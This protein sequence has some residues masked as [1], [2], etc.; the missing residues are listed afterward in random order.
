MPLSTYEGSYFEHPSFGNLALSAAELEARVP[1]ICG[2]PEAGHPETT[3]G[4]H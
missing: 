1:S 4:N 2:F 3:A